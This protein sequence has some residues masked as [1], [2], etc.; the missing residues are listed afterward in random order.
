MVYHVLYHLNRQLTRR[1]H[2]PLSLSVLLILDEERFSFE[3]FYAQRD[4]HRYTIKITM[5]IMLR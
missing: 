5:N 2:D 4:Q 1:I 3:I